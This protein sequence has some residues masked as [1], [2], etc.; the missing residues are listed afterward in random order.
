MSCVCE[1]GVKRLCFSPVCV[2][3]MF[4]SLI[5][6]KCIITRIVRSLVIPEITNRSQMGRAFLT[7]LSGKLGKVRIEKRFL[8]IGSLLFNYPENR[9]SAVMM[10]WEYSVCFVFLFNFCSKHFSL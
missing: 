4:D 9:K 1:V 10:C 3:C 6:E 2:A 8:H 7:C 5:V